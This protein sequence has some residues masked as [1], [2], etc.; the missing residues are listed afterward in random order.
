M[1]KDVFSAAAAAATTLAGIASAMVGIITLTVSL[2]LLQRAA[3]RWLARY[4]Y[5]VLE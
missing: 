3:R 2:L 4:P 1:S 5:N